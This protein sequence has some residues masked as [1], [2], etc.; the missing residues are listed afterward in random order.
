M[1]FDRLFERH[2]IREDSGESAKTTDSGGKGLQ[3]TTNR[4]FNM[5]K[6]INSSDLTCYL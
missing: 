5:N 3:H 2:A 4:L 1:Y 6:P